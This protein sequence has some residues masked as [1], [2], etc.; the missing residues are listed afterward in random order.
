MK[1]GLEDASSKITTQILNKVDKREPTS[2]AFL[3][4]A[5]AF[6]TIDHQILLIK[7]NR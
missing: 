3:D 5:K 2:V 7:S 4:Q 1:L 6:D